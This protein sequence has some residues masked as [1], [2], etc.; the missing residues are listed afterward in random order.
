MG[1]KKTK[2]MRGDR[3]GLLKAA[4]L[5]AEL[6]GEYER[7]RDGAV[8]V[9]VECPDD[10]SWDDIEVTHVNR[11][12]RWQVKRLKQDLAAEDAS[13]LLASAVSTGSDGIR[14]ILGVAAFVPVTKGTK[15]LF[16]MRDLAELCDEA[17]RPGTDAALFAMREK[18]TPAFKFVSASHAAGTGPEAILATLQ[19]LH[20]QELGME[21]AI[22]A[23]A[24]THLHDF[25]S[26]ADEVFEEIHSWFIKNPD[27]TVVVD[28][29]LLYEHVVDRVAKRDPTRSRWIYVARD[30][31]KATWASHGPLTHERLVDVAWE[32]GQ[33]RVRVGAPPVAG[34]AV[35][36]A[37]ARLALH[38]VNGVAL[39]T[40]TSDVAEWT[41]HS[42][43]LCGGTL[44]K[45]V[46]RPQCGWEALTMSPPTH[47]PRS[48]TDTPAFATLL[49]DAM[50]KRVWSRYVSAVGKHLIEDELAAD[51]QP[52]MH[53]IW[54]AWHACLDADPSRRASFLR[55]MLATVEEWGRKGFDRSVRVGS[56]LV[57]ELARATIVAVAIAAAFDGGNV[58]SEVGAAGAI[59]NLRFGTVGAHVVA[60]ASASHPEDRRPWRLADAAGP[61]FASEA[62]IAILGLVEASA[63]EIF[64][65]A[66]E[67]AVPFHASD[68][69]AQNF[70]HSG[71]PP[72]V[73][74]ASP[75]F[76]A[77]LAKGIEAVKK[78][79]SDVLGR[80]NDLR[81]ES[82]RR[83]LEGAS[84]NG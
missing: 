27:A 65:V 19:Q 25:F 10:E 26:N 15:V 49:S 41:A 45:S 23:R 14:R 62:G 24:R 57:E 39:E 8:K 46:S 58:P 36:S 67:E 48:E 76:V 31:V 35:S 20:I 9:R 59:S 5:A 83:A 75:K 30:P 60:L 74:T 13:E 44:G 22:R 32:A 40:A 3:Y 16:N 66:V 82:L 68:S 55:S 73:L 42:L 79:L 33:G 53:A 34:D 47:V 43:G 51:L 80:M 64:D 12:D 77:A 81:F 1:P 4:E 50:D 56:S 29:G 11:M 78:H 7:A 61:M 37:L 72:P 69:A 70:R 17:R 63:T 2:L 84:S 38:R 52:K 6:V 28:V 54:S 21:E 71:S 18:K